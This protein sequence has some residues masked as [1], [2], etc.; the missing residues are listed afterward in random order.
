M[1]YVQTKQ[2]TLCKLESHNFN[3]T[4]TEQSQPNFWQVGTLPLGF[5]SVQQDTLPVSV[6]GDK[7]K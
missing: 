1:C 5:F 3:G 6:C 2:F 4:V 7:A